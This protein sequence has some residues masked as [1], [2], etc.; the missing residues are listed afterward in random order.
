MDRSTQSGE[1]VPVGNDLES[2][3]MRALAIV[4]L[5]RRLLIGGAIV[6]MVVGLG[7]ALLS[8]RHYTTTFSFMPQTAADGNRS[9]LA[10]LAGQ[11]GVSLG[12]I[13]GQATP[14]QF[15]A[16]LLGTR[17][18]L[19]PIAADS[20]PVDRGAKG[21]ESISSIVG[22]HGQSHAEEIDRTVKKLRDNV[23]STTVATRT[24][25]VV[26]VNVETRSA[27]A[28]LEIARQ[29]LLG[30]T[31]FN[32]ETRQ[33]QAAAERRFVE[34]RL[35]T[36]KQALADAEARLS[37]FQE[38]NR[39]IANSP[40]LNF[41][42]DRL[43]REVT[44]EQDLVGSLT[45]QYE[46]ARIREVRDTPVITVIDQPVL[47]VTADPSGAGRIVLGSATVAFLLVLCIVLARDR[48][49]R[50]LEAHGIESWGS[51]ARTPRATA[52]KDA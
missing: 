27:R 19:D 15:Y 47:A 4:A 40:A 2:P 26:S 9:G 25:G 13:T 3:V 1:G 38:S 5:K 31:K 52:I 36:A 22:A 6:G 18:V 8:P 12:S 14:P 20:V 49:R 29:L 17:A 10:S 33:S 34:G 21:Y 28:S 51:L 30:L 11:F 42:Q 41:Q 39:A 37:G 24:T 32:L 50:E 43:R 48:L 7:I 16:D 23:I 46:D 45:Q 44:T 35:S